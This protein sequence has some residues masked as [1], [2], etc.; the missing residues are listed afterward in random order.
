MQLVKPVE[1]SQDAAAV[2]KCLRSVLALACAGELKGI[3]IACITKD[4][5]F[6]SAYEAPSTLELLG[7]SAA[8]QAELADAV[9]Y[10][11]TE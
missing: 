10:P 4:D 1:V 9:F 2:I 6:M 11:D 7:A 3:A 8:L 5:G